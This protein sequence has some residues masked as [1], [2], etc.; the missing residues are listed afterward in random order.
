MTKMFY[1]ITGDDIGLSVVN[2]VYISS[3]QSVVC[4]QLLQ[5]TQY[6]SVDNGGFLVCQYV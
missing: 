5:G 1:N 6:I 2:T 3:S 4:K